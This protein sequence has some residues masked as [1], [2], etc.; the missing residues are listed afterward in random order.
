MLPAVGQGRW[1]L[2]AARM[3][4]THWRRS[5]RS[6][7]VETHAAVTAERALLDAFARRLHGAGWRVGL[8]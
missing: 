1:G 4:M 7:I 8:D 6:T 5:C 3:T 2:N